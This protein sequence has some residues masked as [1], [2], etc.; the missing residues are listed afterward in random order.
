MLVKELIERLQELD[1]ELPVYK[2]F[3]DEGY[4]EQNPI[5]SVFLSSKAIY[6][7]YKIIGYI[8]LVEIS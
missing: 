5:N 1:P 2:S 7:G 3:M 8:P 6:E 4:P